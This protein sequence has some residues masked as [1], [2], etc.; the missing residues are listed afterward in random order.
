MSSIKRNVYVF[1]ICFEI[2]LLSVSLASGEIEARASEIH[3]GDPGND[4][5]SCHKEDFDPMGPESS[6]SKAERTVSKDIKS[7]N[8]LQEQGGGT[9]CVSC[10]DN[11]GTGASKHIDAS[12]IKQGV[13]RNLNNNTVN[14]TLPSDPVNKACWACHGNGTEPSGEHPINY[15]TPYLC[16][17]CHSKTIN[18]SSTNASRIP[19]LTTR[20]VSEHI[21]QPYFDQINSTVNDSNANC[22]GCHDKSKVVFS[23][24]GFSRAADVSHYASRTDLVKPSV[25]CSLCHKDSQNASAYW[26]NM[27][28]HPAKSQD[29]SFCDNCHNTTSA[30]DLHSQPLVKPNN[31]HYGFD[32]QNDD[33]NEG[34]PIGTNEACMS[35]HG[36][37]YTVYKLCED[38]HIENRS[39]PVKGYYTRSDINDT[40]PRV[41][42]H[43]NFSTEVNVPNQSTVYSPSQKAKTFSSCYAFNNVTLE[44]TC[45][46]NS[47][48]NLSASGGFYAFKLISN[49]TRSTPYHFTQTIDRLPDTKNC[50]FCHNQTDAVIR[51]AWGNATQITSG[52]HSWYTESNNSKCWRCHVN[53]G[54]APVDFHSES[55]T[56]GG[57]S[58][59]ISCHA[60][61]V[62]PDV[63]ISLFGRHAKIN[64]SNGAGNV[65]NDDCWTCHYQKDMDRNHV[66]MCEKCHD[67]SSGIVNVTDPALIKSD[68]MHGITSCKTCH[69][70]KGYHGKGTVG[71]LGILENILKKET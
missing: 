23:D 9:D 36:T 67:N 32:W 35:C 63:N 49:D 47:Y 66:Y 46:G 56:G 70:P 19:D 5:I 29:D 10:H 17:D 26:A 50:V 51:K 2:L 31:I 40:L 65:T 16:G 24:S 18:L 69:A 45:H 38:C 42:A 21:Q 13:H 62:N 34:D 3:T 37:H 60:P 1:I 52:R 33:Q 27:I 4:C 59:C 8:I 68:F 20:I 6:I 71:P 39:G 30:T 43:T 7:N 53:T 22:D 15:E 54:T 41:Y 14:S 28:R 48:K 58:D 57:G 64:D 55:V 11:G 25:N 12:A 61:D 44:G